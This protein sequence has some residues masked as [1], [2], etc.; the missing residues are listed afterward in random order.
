MNYECADC[1]RMKLSLCGAERTEHRRCI[2]WSDIQT[3]PGNCSIINNY[4]WRRGIVPPDFDGTVVTWTWQLSLGSQLVTSIIM[5]GCIGRWITT[6]LGPN[7]HQFNTT[8]RTW[9]S[10]CRQIQR[11]F[12]IRDN[13]FR[14]EM[15]YIVLLLVLVLKYI[16][17]YLYLTT[18]GKMSTT[19]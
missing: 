12:T 19:V 1:T 15:G 7:F 4:S 18:M 5:P 10:D 16:L 17:E 8:R 6:T 14:A 13:I 2:F 3:S 11:T 9:S